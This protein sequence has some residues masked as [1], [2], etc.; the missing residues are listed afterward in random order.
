MQSFGQKLGAQAIISGNMEELGE[1]YRIRLRTLEVET[2]RVLRVSSVNVRK[3]DPQI[4]RLMRGKGFLDTKKLVFGVSGG[5]GLGLSA[6]E[7]DIKDDYGNPSLVITAGWLASVY[8]AY[9]ENRLF[10]LQLEA[11]E[12]KNSLLIEGVDNIMYNNG[13]YEDD[14]SIYRP[15]SGESKIRDLFTYISLDIP[16]LARLNFRP[17]P[18]MLVSVQAGPYISLPLGEMKNEFHYPNFSQWNGSRDD[19][20]VNMQVGI[21]AGVS[22]GISVGPG[23]ISARARFMQDLAPVTVEYMGGNVGGAETNLFTRRAIAFLI[24]YELWI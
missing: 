3:D 9:N 14:G 21:L 2:A 19:K 6:I 23:Y 13:V 5:L 15:S 10:A 18:A 22:A 12:L 4:G 8:F 1:Y 20:I 17:I 16:L 11:N 7:D 24:G